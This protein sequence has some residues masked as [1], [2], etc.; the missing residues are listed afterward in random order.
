MRRDLDAARPAGAGSVA[1]LLQRQIEAVRAEGRAG[2]DGLRQ[3][4]GDLG[5]RVRDE[6]GRAAVSRWPASSRASSAEV[7]QQLGDG[8][9]LFQ[10]AQATMGDRPSTAPRRWWGKCRG[11]SAKLGEATQRVA[12]VGP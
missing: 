7:T 10:S 4:V 1:E 11:A 12:D 6:L 9:R 8:M 5:G 2:Q 3:E